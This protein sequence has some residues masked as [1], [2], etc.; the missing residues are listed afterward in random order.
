MSLSMC[1]WNI[2]ID[3]IEHCLLDIRH[4]LDNVSKVLNQRTESTPP[5]LKAVEGVTHHHN[6][7]KLL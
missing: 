2:A 4:N 6:G 1:D 7:D 5:I 3:K